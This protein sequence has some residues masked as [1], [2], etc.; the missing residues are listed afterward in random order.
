MEVNRNPMNE[1]PKVDQ[2]AADRII[3]TAVRTVVNGY[4]T[5]T[6]DRESAYWMLLH[7]GH[8]ADMLLCNRPKAGRR[9]PTA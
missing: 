4:Q 5:G 2:E 7:A 1:S 6:V 3:R 8:G 9:T